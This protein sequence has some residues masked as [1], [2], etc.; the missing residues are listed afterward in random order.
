MHKNWSLVDG[1]REE[2]YSNIHAHPRLG[3]SSFITSSSCFSCSE[4]EFWTPVNVESACF[5]YLI[6]QLAITIFVKLCHDCISLKEGI[7]E[8]LHSTHLFFCQVFQQLLE[9]IFGQITIV[10]LVKVLKRKKNDITLN[11]K[12]TLKA[13][14]ALLV[15]SVAE[16]IPSLF[17]S[18]LAISSDSR[19]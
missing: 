12:L 1:S 5:F 14:S 18:R 16:I 6:V 17:L 4:E 3:G 11:L 2:Q 15:S 10:V 19:K 7:S 9:L 13:S 8:L